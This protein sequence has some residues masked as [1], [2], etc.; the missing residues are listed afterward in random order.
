M[1]MRARRTG[2]DLTKFGAVGTGIVVIIL[3][4]NKTENGP[5]RNYNKINVKKKLPI[6]HH[7]VVSSSSKELG[8]YF[9]AK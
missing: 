1:E 7:I 6:S 5:I 2:D 3:I 8:H 9:A 4:Y